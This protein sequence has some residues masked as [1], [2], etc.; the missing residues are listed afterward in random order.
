MYKQI[1]IMLYKIG[2]ASMRFVYIR[3]V[4]YKIAI[5]IFPCHKEQFFTN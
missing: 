1:T 3:V 4:L 2:I 5:T